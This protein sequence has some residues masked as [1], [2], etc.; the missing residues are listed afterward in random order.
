MG[1]TDIHMGGYPRMSTHLLQKGR[2]HP[3]TLNSGGHIYVLL[4][5]PTFYIE[6]LNSKYIKTLYI[7]ML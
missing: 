1:S 2:P 3:L 6:N 5:H 7:G 4:V